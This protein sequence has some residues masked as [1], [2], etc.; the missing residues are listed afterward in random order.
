MF[1]FI[2]VS[3][4]A[5][6]AKGTKAILEQMVG[7]T[8]NLKIKVAGGDEDGGIG[9][10]T[11]KI[12]SAIESLKETNHIF[13]FTDIGSSVMSS[14]MAVDL[15]DDEALKDKIK[16]S[17]G[18]FIEGAFEAAVNASVGKSADELLKN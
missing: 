10:S 14:E 4:S 11:E 7:D 3:H 8:E 2:L 15:I 5:D 6:V 1:G 13:I 9:T 16:I 17:E 18:P 12:Q